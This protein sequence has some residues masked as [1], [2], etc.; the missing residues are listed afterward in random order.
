MIKNP[1]R[2]MPSFGWHAHGFAWAWVRAWPRKAVAMAPR[3]KRLMLHVELLVTDHRMSHPASGGIRTRS[4]ACP[5]LCVGMDESMGKSM[6]TQSRGHAT[7]RRLTTDYR[8]F[9][10]EGSV[11]SAWGKVRR[12]AAPGSN[13]MKNLSVECGTF[14][15]KMAHDARAKGGRVIL[16][17]Y[18]D[19]RI[20]DFLSKEPAL[21]AGQKPITLFRNRGWNDLIDF[22]EQAFTPGEIERYFFVIFLVRISI[23]KFSVPEPAKSIVNG[24]FS[25]SNLSAKRLSPP[26]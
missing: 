26:P 24:V 14:S 19:F 5:R 21:Q 15:K 17:S 3:Q 4:V 16:V 8:S 25:E 9:R 12:A 2:G 18:F 20:W 1:V 13:E 7:R 6:P 10:P 23:S 22:A 11:L